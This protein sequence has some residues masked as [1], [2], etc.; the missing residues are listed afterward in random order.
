MKNFLVLLIG[1][2][3]FS[4][5]NVLSQQYEEV[6]YLKNG[7]IIHGLI[8]EQVPNVSVKI[9]TR[10]GN[11]FVYKMDEIEKITK[12]IPE[13]SN[14][15]FSNYN[16]ARNGFFNLWRMGIMTAGSISAEGGSGSFDE[17]V[18]AIGSIAGSRMSDIFRLGFGIEYNNYP[19]GT[20]APLFLDFRLNILQNN[21]TPIFFIDAG[22]SL[23][24]IKNMDGMN[25]DG[26][27]I[28]I[29]TGVEFALPN[30]TALFLEL[31][32]RKQWSE[33][34]INQY[35]YNGYNYYSYTDN[36][37]ASYNFLALMLGYTF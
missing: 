17:S 36:I 16:T 18:F 10:D 30:S 7:S 25:G 13:S 24:W 28:N 11:V 20:T 37:K 1:T 15:S 31:S 2:F 32:Y 5:T 23:A 33:I 8:I 4:F 6:V 35:G 26:A 3:I 22:Y 29:G 34:I 21:I 27:F 12:E 9:K 19:N 14:Q